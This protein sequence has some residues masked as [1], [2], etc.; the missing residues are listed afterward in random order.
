MI[1]LAQMRFPKPEFKDYVE[2][3]LKLEERIPDTL[4]LR[5]GI[6]A[7]LLLL[8]GL[9][10]YHWRS[11]KKLQLLAACSLLIFGFLFT[12]CP[13]P[14]GMYQNLT[15]ALFS[16]QAVPLAIVVLFVLPLAVA[17]SG[18]DSF[19]WE[20]AQSAHC[21]NCCILKRSMSPCGWIESD[22]KSLC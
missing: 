3:V 6:L 9:S 14:I 20:A 22:G 2:P 11:R 16:G 21:R 1:F 4:W 17:L 5:V 15:A 7:L 12:A 13:C 10:L 8:T 19:A 18:E